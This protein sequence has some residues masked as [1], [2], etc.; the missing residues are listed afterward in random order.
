MHRNVFEKCYEA[1]TRVINRSFLQPAKL[2]ELYRGMVM[3]P[4][5]SFNNTYARGVAIFENF[6]D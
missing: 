2:E 4:I 1:V 3:S 6:R 5:E